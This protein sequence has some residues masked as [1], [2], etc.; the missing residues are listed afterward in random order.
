MVKS[1]PSS[2]AVSTILSPTT[3][4]DDAPGGTATFHARFSFGPN[5]TG[6]FWSS[7]TPLPAGPR[8]CGQSPA[9]RGTVRARASERHRT[10][11]V[12]RDSKGEE[13]ARTGSE[14]ESLASIPEGAQV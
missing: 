14:V 6:G 13:T 2:N 5:F 11:L 1:L 8:N 4:G 7:A 9:L 3:M 12:I 10:N